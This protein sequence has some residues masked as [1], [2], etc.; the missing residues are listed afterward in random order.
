MGRKRKVPLSSSWLPARL[1][2]LRA[3]SGFPLNAW[4][5]LWANSLQG[6]GSHFTTHPAFEYSQHGQ[7]PGTKRLT[8]R[9]RKIALGSH[10]ASGAAPGWGWGRRGTKRWRPDALHL[11]VPRV[12]SN[13]SCCSKG[14]SQLSQQCRHPR[15]GTSLPCWLQFS[16]N[17]AESRLQPKSSRSVKFPCSGHSLVR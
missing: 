8:A 5:I 6:N 3:E 14:G 15:G 1:M 9:H 7:A 17:T 12:L 13:R 11:S 4:A 10:G 2:A 16:C